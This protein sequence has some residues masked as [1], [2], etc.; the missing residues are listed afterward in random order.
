MEG[1]GKRLQLVMQT[2]KLTQTALSK[3]IGLTQPEISYYLH[4]KIKLVTNMDEI[5][6]IKIVLNVEMYRAI[7]LKSL[8]GLPLS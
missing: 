3:I 8:L 2:L 6:I 1:F 5:I 7:L 4:E